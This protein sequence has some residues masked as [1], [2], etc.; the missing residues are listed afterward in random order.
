MEEPYWHS[1]LSEPDHYRPNYGPSKKRSLD[2]RTV[3]GIAHQSDYYRPQYALSHTT[4]IE[5]SKEESAHG[6]SD[7]IMDFNGDTAQGASRSV[8]PTGVFADRPPQVPPK[9][10][11]QWVKLERHSFVDYEP[12]TIFR[13]THLEPQ[14]GPVKPNDKSVAETRFGN[15]SAKV[16]FFVVLARFRFGFIAAPIYSHSN[17]GV[18]YLPDEIKGQTVGFTTVGE[19]NVDAGSNL[20]NLEIIPPLTLWATSNLYFMKPVFF[21][22]ETETG[23]CGS[24]T[25]QSYHRLQFFFEAEFRRGASFFNMTTESPLDE[26]LGFDVELPSLKFAKSVYHQ[27]AGAF[28]ASAP[29]LSSPVKGKPSVDVPPPPKELPPPPPPTL[30]TYAKTAEEVTAGI[31]SFTVS[32]SGLKKKPFRELARKAIAVFS[33]NVN[34]REEADR[35][36]YL[37]AK[38]QITVQRRI[39]PAMSGTSRGR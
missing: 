11:A 6:S 21:D 17:H 34:M 37:D 7:G 14:R 8:T 31:Q 29:L 32:D 33:N 3:L 12:G 13:A 23:I 22:Y 39:R 38:S 28:S 27:S 15:Y 4:L 5:H 24:I 25:A 19:A 26:P 10:H 18:H 16:R 2:G 20:G 36:R 35:K 30:E 9:P 1:A